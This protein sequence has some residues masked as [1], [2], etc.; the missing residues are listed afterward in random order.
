[1]ATLH[2]IHQPVPALRPYVKCYL[3][4]YM[5]APGEEVGCVLPAKLEQCIFFSI[6]HVPVI[7]SPATGSGNIL[8]PDSCCY[9]RGGVSNSMLELRIQGV[10]AMF[11]VIFH[12]T[13]FY[14]LFG[15]PMHH[16]AN[17]FTQAGISLGK[18]WETLGVQVREATTIEDRIALAEGRLLQQLSKRII[19]SDAIDVTTM[20]LLQH[21]EM[22]VWM[23]ARN[24]Y[25]SERQFRRRF[26][27]RTG[28]SPQNFARI[29]RTNKA[30]Q[31]KQQQ[32]QKSWES[33]AMETG[34]TDKSHL[35]REMK[36]LMGLH[37]SIDNSF[38]DVQGTN[39][40][41][42]ERR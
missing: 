19:T 30:L 3:E 26:I 1:M 40:K 42:L 23:M 39:F 31:L 34:Y 32:P 6:G 10:L 12:P 15:V 11:V 13:G 36:A 29:C 33:V 18:D 14:R 35:R 22:P 8:S 5:G 38:I 7:A 21:T 37:H 25:L 17:T 16:F 41:L 27:D 24:S 20:Q 4:I 9:V 28:L 2:H